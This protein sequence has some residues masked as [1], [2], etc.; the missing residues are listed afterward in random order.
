VAAAVRTV[1]PQ[2]FRNNMSVKGEPVITA[3][4]STDNW[5]CI[6]FKPDLAKFGMVRG[7]ALQH[8]YPRRPRHAHP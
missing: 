8:I 6:T 7:C 2:V 4:K 5:T 3:C 1:R